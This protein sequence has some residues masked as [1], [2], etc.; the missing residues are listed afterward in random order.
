MTEAIGPRVRRDD[1]RVGVDAL[2]EISEFKIS[3]S[4][5]S[6]FSRRKA[7]EVCQSL[8]NRARA[9][10]W[11]GGRRQGCC[12]RHPLE[13]DQWTHLARQGDRARPRLGAAPPSAPPTIRPSTVP[14][15]RSGQ[16]SLCPLQGSLL[17]ND[18]SSNRT[19][20]G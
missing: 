9:R 7:S 18:P 11:S 19:R 17:E 3:N 2:C 20:S 8:A 4:Q 16:L 6:T 15:P 12:V 14:G 1:D 10:G 5:A 13:A